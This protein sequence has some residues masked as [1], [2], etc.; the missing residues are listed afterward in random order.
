MAVFTYRAAERGGGGGDVVE[1][2]IEAP[3]RDDAA[4]RLKDSG[5]IPLKI[6]V[7]RGEGGRRFFPGSR[8]EDVLTFFTEL[9]VLL[10]AG[11][12][13]D[14]SLA[15]LANISES[16]AM[17]EVVPSVLRYVREGSSLSDAMRRHPRVFKRLHVSMV[18]AGE[19]GGVLDVVLERLVEFLESAKGLKEQVFSAMIYPIVLLITAGTSIVILLTYVLPKFTVIFEDFGKSLPLSTA[20]LMTVSNTL[21]SLWWV[22]AIIVVAG[23]F[24]FRRYTSKEKGRLKWDALKLWLFGRIIR[25]LETARFSRTLGTL[26]NSG[27]PLLGALENVRDVV[28][29]TVISSSVA[30]ITKGA[31]EGR[32]IAQPMAETGL[33]PELAVSM[34]RVGEE[35]GRL[36]EMLI[37]VAVTYEKSL[38]VTIKRFMG[39]VEP[40]LLLVMGVIVGFIVLSML[41]AIFSV[42]E[43]PF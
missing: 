5:L 18:K 26:L 21:I 12:P 13:L 6:T 30:V 7:P 24:A 37:K 3:D 33:Y 8:M 9:S 20:M 39:L 34:I 23:G 22:I 42:N 38:E 15:I 43:L 19:S 1:G 17:K 41:M 29:N 4:R 2:V 32:G 28:G 11:L 16:R 36:D 40:V 25:K 31:K 10:N 27:V 14:R 35:T